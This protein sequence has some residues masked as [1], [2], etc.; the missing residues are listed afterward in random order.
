[1]SKRTTKSTDKKADT[2]KPA[3]F[4]LADLAKEMH[5]DPKAV[6]AKFRRLYNADDT[7]GLPKITDKK[8][9]QFAESDRDRVIEL[10]TGNANTEADENA[11]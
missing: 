1:M 5:K 3:T 6:R 9:W 10:V 4:Y 11:A 7:S 8:R 2:P